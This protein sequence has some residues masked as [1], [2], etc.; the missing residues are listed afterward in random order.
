MTFLVAEMNPLGWL[1]PT[2]HLRLIERTLPI[3]KDETHVYFI[4]LQS[5]W[6]DYFQRSMMTEA[7]ISNPKRRQTRLYA[8]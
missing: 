5:Q 2:F 1:V 6:D 4:S 3:S 7:P 8:L